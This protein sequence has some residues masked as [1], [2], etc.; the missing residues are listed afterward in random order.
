MAQ[1]ATAPGPADYDG[2]G[3]ADVAVF[4]PDGAN[5]FVQRNTIGILIQQFGINGDSPTPASFVP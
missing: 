1:T 3:R 2:D 4:R 5:W